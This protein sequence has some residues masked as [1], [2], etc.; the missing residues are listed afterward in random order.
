MFSLNH[1]ALRTRNTCQQGDLSRFKVHRFSLDH[2]ALINIHH[3][4]SLEH[5]ARN[6]PMFEPPSLFLFGALERR[7]TGNHSYPTFPGVRPRC[8]RVKIHCHYI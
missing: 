3:S 6:I 1:G 7:N 8:G 4:V 5:R 2:C